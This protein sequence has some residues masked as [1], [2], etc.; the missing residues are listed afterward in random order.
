MRNSVIERTRNLRV[1]TSSILYLPK[2]KPTEN[3][4]IGEQKPLCRQ[5][6]NITSS[7]AIDLIFSFLCTSRNSL[8]LYIGQRST[9]GYKCHDPC[10][11]VFL[12]ETE[13]MTIMWLTVTFG[14][15][16]FYLLFPFC[17][18]TEQRDDSGQRHDRQAWSRL[19]L[20]SRLS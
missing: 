8:S 7:R 9:V 6:G 17:R 10:S 20:R 1:T 19:L 15:Y 12:M 3:H 14:G 5:L 2:C 13:V 18:P 11:H 4:A 16:I